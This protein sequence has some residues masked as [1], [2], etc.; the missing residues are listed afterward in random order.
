L[1]DAAIS[2][3][4]MVGFCDETIDDHQETLSLMKQVGYDFAFMFKYSERSGTYAAKYLNDN[5]P[6]KE[7]IRRLNE[8]I[9][10]QNELSYESKKQDV[11]KVFE[12]LVEGSSKKSKKQMMGRNSQNKVI[13]FDATDNV[14]AGNFVKVKVESFTSATFW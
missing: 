9:A 1:P 14:C 10:L 13:V 7:K 4:I 2:T 8:V 5:V 11:G 3:D 12:V 6:E